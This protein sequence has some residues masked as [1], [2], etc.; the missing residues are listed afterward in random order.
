MIRAIEFT[1]SVS[2]CLSCHFCP[3][4]KLAGAYNSDVKKMTL[5]DFITIVHKLPDDV[6]LDFSGFSEPFLNPLCGQMIFHASQQGRKIN[7]YTTLMGLSES[8][9]DLLKQSKIEYIRIHVPDNKGLLIKNEPWLRQ[10]NLFLTTKLPFTA[11]AMGEIDN[12]LAVILD[13]RG[14]KVEI[15]TM[16]NRAGN[17]DWL[18]A[19][20]PISGGVTCAAERY[21]QNVVL[22]D[23]TVAGCC[24]DYSIEKNLGNLLTESYE[25]I[26][27]RAEEWSK[28]TNPP[29][30]SMCRK[31]SWA[32]PV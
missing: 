6:E 15:P 28:D 12:T 26:S 7:L 30:S 14:V 18:D 11:M 3:Q 10:F 13:K 4:D 25:T 17:L 24:C 16:I 5:S 32:K 2:N 9:S 27:Q 31:C 23:G 29:Q 8:Q 22:P 19:G 21:H 20:R 1:L